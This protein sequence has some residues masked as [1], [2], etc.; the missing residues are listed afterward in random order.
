MAGIPIAVW[1]MPVT[2][3]AIIPARTAQIRAT[4]RFAPLSIIMTQTAPPVA[5]VPSTVRS[6]ISKTLY[7]R[8]TPIAITPQIRPWAMAPGSALISDPIF[9]PYLRIIRWQYSQTES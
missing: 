3:P 7:V 8:Y 5:I 6:A 1:K 9:K 4:Q 2:R